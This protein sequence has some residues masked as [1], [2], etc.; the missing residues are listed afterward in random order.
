MPAQERL[1]PVDQLLAYFMGLGIIIAI[2]A[3]WLGSLEGVNTAL[4]SSLLL[5]GLA[6]LIL[7][8]IAW[9]YLSRPWTTFD[10]LTTPYYTGGHDEPDVALMVSEAAP[11]AVE[12]AAPPA[13]VEEPA[14]AAPPAGADDLTQIHGIGPKVQSVLNDAGIRTYSDLAQTTPDELR[15]LLREAGLRLSNPDEWPAKAAQAD[16]ERSSA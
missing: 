9:L 12:E 4:A 10:D 5:V 7:G 3:F 8:T 14:D 13:P 11:P 1:H 6:I 15:A 16:R 2:I